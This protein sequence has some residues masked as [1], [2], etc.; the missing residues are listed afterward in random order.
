MNDASIFID[1]QMMSSDL[2]T[3]GLHC[4]AAT[5]CACHGSGPAIWWTL[6][7]RCGDLFHSLQKVHGDGHSISVYQGVVATWHILTYL[8]VSI[9]N[10]WYDPFLYFPFDSLVGQ[11]ITPPRR[12]LAPRWDLSVLDW[13]MGGPVFEPHQ[14][15]PNMVNVICF[16][17]KWQIQFCIPP[18]CTDMGM[19]QNWVAQ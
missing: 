16:R 2:E 7:S 8:D 6:D 14:G 9:S 4:P 10:M 12:R 3:Q 1:I 18:K 19:G 17:P 11:V 5:P 13:R 15:N